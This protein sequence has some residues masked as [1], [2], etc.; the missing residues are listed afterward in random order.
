[1]QK[2]GDRFEEDLFR[3][4]FSWNLL[5][6]HCAPEKCCTALKE[7]DNVATRVVKIEFWLKDFVGLCVEHVKHD[8]TVQLEATDW[9]AVNPDIGSHDCDRLASDTSTWLAAAEEVSESI[10]NIL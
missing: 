1:M 9:A 8:Q 6:L 10:Y 4:Y 2:P 7:D 5:A 3:V